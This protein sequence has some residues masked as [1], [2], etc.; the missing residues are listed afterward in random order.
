MPSSKKARKVVKK[1]NGIFPSHKPT[2]VKPTDKAAMDRERASSI[3]AIL[4]AV[5]FYRGTLAPEV[6]EDYERTCRTLINE[7]QNSL[8]VRDDVS[9]ID[10]I[11]IFSANTFKE[12]VEKGQENM[13]EWSLN[14]LCKGVYYIR[15]NIPESQKDRADEI[16]H[17]REKYMDIYRTIIEQCRVL[18][19]KHAE[20]ASLDRK[21]QS[22]KEEYDKWVKDYRERMQHVEERA[23]YQEMLDKVN[24]PAEM[25][26]Q[27]KDLQKRLQQMKSR[28]SAVKTSEVEIDALKSTLTK[29]N[30]ELDLLR[31]ALSHEPNVYDPNLS[32]KIQDRIKG[33]LEHIESMISDAKRY[34]EDMDA[35]QGAL[36]AMG[37]SYNEMAM[38][39]SAAQFADY[40]MKADEDLIKY[41]RMAQESIRMDKERRER[42]QAERLRMQ[43]EEQELERERAAAS[44]ENT[45]KETQWN[46][47]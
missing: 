25:S 10:D 40:L 38:A 42:V 1:I 39:G 44:E 24:R 32:V 19:D 28:L 29:L 12:S 34:D 16:L 20:L 5:D 45:E 30:S 43:K 33:E 21:H 27:A 23:A 46:Y 11:L 36:K 3:I 2:Q 41:E 15:D 17:E 37:N 8:V 26:A 4:E 22:L 7:L 13:A 18:D 14:A 47:N 9:R 35:L 31:I 6:R